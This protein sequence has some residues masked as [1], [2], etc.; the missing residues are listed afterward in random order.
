MNL[1]IQPYNLTVPSPESHRMRAYINKFADLTEQSLSSSAAVIY[2]GN[3]GPTGS[4]WHPVKSSEFTV[5]Y[6]QLKSSGPF[7]NTYFARLDRVAYKHAMLCIQ[8][9]LYEV[10]R[11]ISQKNIQRVVVF[12]PW[13]VYLIWTLTKHLKYNPYSQ[14]NMYI[15]VIC[16]PELVE[17]LHEDRLSGIIK[18]IT[19]DNTYPIRLLT[20]DI[21]LCNK[22]LSVGVHGKQI[23]KLP[24]NQL[25]VTVIENPELK[26]MVTLKLPEE[27][28]VKH[29][30]PVARLEIRIPAYCPLEPDMKLDMDLV[31][32]NMYSALEQIVDTLTLKCKTQDIRLARHLQQPGIHIV[33]DIACY[34]TTDSNDNIAYNH[35]LP[36]SQPHVDWS[37]EL[38]CRLLSMSLLPYLG[39]VDITVA[40]DAYWE[41]KPIGLNLVSEYAPELMFDVIDVINDDEP[42]D[43][44]S[45][46]I[47]LPVP[48]I[49]HDILQISETTNIENSI[50]WMQHVNELYDFEHDNP[51]L[52]ATD[53]DDLWILNN[54]TDFQTMSMSGDNPV[55][56]VISTPPT[57]ESIQITNEVTP[58]P[59]IEL[60]EPVPPEESVIE[61]AKFA[62]VSSRS[63]VES[64]LGNRLLD[65][66]DTEWLDGAQFLARCAAS[67][68]HIFAVSRVQ[69]RIETI[70]E[71][72]Q[73]RYEP[74][75]M[76]HVN[77]VYYNRL[78]PDKYP[79]PY[80]LYQEI[81]IELGLI[82]SKTQITCIYPNILFETGVNGM[83]TCGTLADSEFQ[84]IGEFVRDNI[85][86]KPVEYF[87]NRVNTLEHSPCLQPG[88]RFRLGILIQVGSGVSGMS[89][90][91]ELL[92]LALAMVGRFS[93][94]IAI[95][96]TDGTERSSAWLDTY[97]EIVNRLNSVTLPVALFA[98]VITI[99]PDL[100]TDISPFIMQF[101]TL[102]NPLGDG[103][104][105]LNLDI[106]YIIKLHTKTN[107]EWRHRLCRPFLGC[108]S[109]TKLIT[110]LD[111]DKTIGMLGAKECVGPNNIFCDTKL[112]TYFPEC[113][114]A[115]YRDMYRYVAGTIFMTRSHIIRD[116]ITMDPKFTKALLCMPYYYDNSLFPTNSPAHTFERIFGYMACKKYKKGVMCI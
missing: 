48:V 70:H 8:R 64:R 29:T 112:E 57:S 87:L 25:V 35:I 77:A 2:F 90:A 80:K 94:V 110:L 33:Y 23:V 108:E 95:N 14:L 68:R 56:Q 65:S 17:L 47:H 106:D 51:A 24:A 36:F 73:F 103:S 44:P 11:V 111:T 6:N 45:S 28:L 76:E 83:I 26:N 50:N 66:G 74:V 75:I 34:F 71:S 99:T 86:N 15:H 21:Q 42:V 92:S 67:S 101:H 62:H 107:T 53:P 16:I 7:P 63:N 59:I 10:Q 55:D 115:K 39:N 78:I 37:Q 4:K 116:T 82:M 54:V 9:Y 30:L 113:T 88:S 19:H 102:T 60:K 43:R 61:L 5:M 20:H 105:G 49:S 13:I 46:Q 109:V 1:V 69:L 58:A 97:R 40:C 31:T 96:F 38:D 98:Y 84:P 52:I 89:I 114:Y 32:G 3:Q 91:G 79:S 81:G 100:G 41:Y 93:I 22:L 85:Y 12:D 72:N 104:S 18:L 27:A